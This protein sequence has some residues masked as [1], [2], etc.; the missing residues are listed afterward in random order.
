MNELYDDKSTVHKSSKCLKTLNSILVFFF[1]F[2]V[3][4]IV[5]YVLFCF[6]TSVDL[7]QTEV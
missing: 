7:E 4:T 2:F 1:F 3:Q 5:F 6:A